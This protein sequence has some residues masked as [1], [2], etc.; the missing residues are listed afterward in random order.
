MDVP[1]IQ[2]SRTMMQLR[3]V[4]ANPPVSP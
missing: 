2:D 3:I 4:D 1:I